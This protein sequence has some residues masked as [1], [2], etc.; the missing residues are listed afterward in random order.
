VRSAIYALWAR[1]NGTSQ[2][3]ARGKEPRKESLLSSKGD[4][5]NGPHR[6]GPTPVR[7]PAVVKFEAVRGG[8]SGERCPQNV[9]TV[10]RG[11]AEGGKL[12]L[13]AG[14]QATGRA[15]PRQGAN[16]RTG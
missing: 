4:R 16:S 5:L 3:E 14:Q 13:L 6:N 2:Q 8:E 12:R 7:V 11:E 1:E 15:E 10:T 9:K